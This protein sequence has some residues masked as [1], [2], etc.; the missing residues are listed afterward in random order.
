MK[1]LLLVFPLLL[2]AFIANAQNNTVQIIA[3]CLH[4]PSDGSIGDG[5]TDTSAS[6]KS[7]SAITEDTAGNLLIWDRGNA[8]IRKI[9]NSTHIVTTIAGTG[10][11]GFSGDGG[12]AVLAQLGAGPFLWN[13]GGICTDS[14]SNIYFADY[15][16]SRIR[17][18]NTVSGIINTIA[19]GG[20]SFNDSIDA[21]TA[22]VKPIKL[23]FHNNLLYFSDSSGK[24]K[25][26][27]LITN[28]LTTIYNNGAPAIIDFYFE[29]SGNLLILN[30]DSNTLKRMMPSGVIYNVAGNGTGYSG[31]GGPANNALLYDSWG[32]IE[33][34][35]GNIFI[36]QNEGVIRRINTSNGNI[37]AICGIPSITLVRQYGAIPNWG[38]YLIRS[39]RFLSCQHKMSADSLRTITRTN[40]FVRR[41]GSVIIA[42]DSQVLQYTPSTYSINTVSV[43]SSSTSPCAI[44]SLTK[45]TIYGTLNGTPPPGDTSINLKVRT[46]DVTTEINLPYSSYIDASGTHFFFGDS[47][48]AVDSTNY[49]WPQTKGFV[50]EIATKSRYPAAFY[51]VDTARA[52]C[53]SDTIIWGV[54]A[55]WDTVMSTYSCMDSSTL[56]KFKIDII[57]G[58]STPES[59]VIPAYPLYI[60]LIYGDG[61]TDTFI[62]NASPTGVFTMEV[63][64]IYNSTWLTSV[65]PIS[66]VTDRTGSITNNWDAEPIIFNE[67]SGSV[68]VGTSISIT[69]GSFVSCSAPFNQQ[70]FLHSYLE[71]SASVFDS[72]VYNLNFGD[73]TDTLVTLHRKADGWGRYYMSD[74]LY[75]NYTIAGVYNTLS[76]T[77]LTG[78]VDTTNA[79]TI[80]NTCSP[81]SGNFY[82]D[83]NMNCVLDSGEVRLGYW[84]FAVRN[85]VSG[86][87]TFWWCDS[88]GHYA[89]TL[90]DGVSYTIIPN[91]LFDTSSSGL[92]VT[93]PATGS[94]TLTTSASTPVTQDFGF[95]C[96]GAPTAVDMHISGWS[97]G[98]IPGDTGVLGIWASNDW[99]YM[100]DSLNSTVTLTLDTN[101]TYAGMWNGPAP[102]T[103]SGSTLT[104]NFHTTANL[105]DFTANV[106]IECATTA[107]MGDYVHNTIHVGQALPLADPDTA[108]N[109]YTWGVPVTTSWDPNEK[110]V[111]PQ[112]YG[113]LGYVPNGTP[114]T[115]TVHF[116][117]TGTARARNI[118]VNDTISEYLDISTLQVVSST[119]PVLVYQD[120]GTRIIRFRF[121]D[122]FLPDSTTN[123]DGSNGYFSFNIYPYPNLP[124]N[125][126][127]HN[128]VG[129]YFDY[130][131][132]VVTNTTTSTIEDTLH[133]IT[134]GAAS[135]CEGSS[136]TFSNALT[137]GVWITSNDHATVTEGIVTGVSAGVDTIYYSM[138]GGD[139][140]VQTI[141]TVNA[142]PHAGI[143]SGPSEVCVGSTIT[144]SGALSGGSWSSS[145]SAVATI[146]DGTVS[147]IAA[148]TAAISYAV[149]NSCGTD[150]ATAPVTVN[151]LPDAGVLSAAPWV[152]VED[153]TTLSSTV[154]GGVWTTADTTI[155]LT[156]TTINGISAGAATLYYAYTNVCGTDVDTLNITVNP[157]PV[158]GTLTGTTVLCMGG[159]ITLTATVPGG[160]WT[161]SSAV[162]TV[163]GGVV[164]GI[165]AGAL[166]I[167]YT[168]SNVCGIAFATR[169]VSVEAPMTPSVSGPTAV[170]TGTTITLTGSGTG[171]TWASSDAAATVV[172]GHVT[173]ISAG[174]AII[175]Y[176]QTNSCG[177]VTD[178][179]LVTV[180][181][182]P[183]AST[184]TGST[185]TCVGGVTTL[186]SAVSG[187]T[188]SSSTAAA[189]VTGG[190]VTGIAAG[191]TIITYT[192]SNMCGSASD[193]MML[194][195]IAPPDAGTISG[196]GVACVG[197]T[198]SLTA[199]VSS[200]TWSSS[201]AT[202][203][204]SPGGIANGVSLGSAIISYSVTNSCGTDVDTMLFSVISLPDAGTI[205][206]TPSVCVGGVST[207]TNTATG[208]EWLSS[209]SDADMVGGVVTGINA[210]TVTIFYSVTNMC[211]NASDTMMMTILPVPSLSAITGTTTLCAGRATTLS[212]STLGGT[213]S[214]SA[215]AI[216]T[217][218]ATGVVSGN[219]TGTTTISYIYSNSCGADTATASITVTTLP[220]AGSL[221]GSASVCPGAV[222]NLTPSIAGGSWVSGN[223]ALATVSSSGSVGG[224]TPGSVTI[225]YIIAN[226]CGADS[227]AMNITV[228][229]IIDCPDNVVAV[230]QPIG[231][232][233]YPN[234]NNGT[235]TISGY[236]AGV[237]GNVNAEI[238]N[239]LGQVI[240]TE[241]LTATNGSIQTLLQPRNLAAGSYTVRLN[242]D[243]GRIVLK[244]TVRD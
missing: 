178:T 125:T 131:P 230:T 133:A 169:S 194:S 86:D 81:L 145:S 91:H 175:S 172:A 6:F 114:F 237:N 121:N 123:P 101:L 241:Q 138:Y 137:G 244:F 127:I 148:G 70:F 7:I 46:G 33:D 212:N 189:T 129:I 80:T 96:A 164:T 155:S 88:M 150:I 188:W 206:G 219:T 67:C 240:Y 141:V 15:G 40:L 149:T 136:I 43:K 203:S 74:T 59:S 47:T 139:Q 134:G 227:A 2:F 120:P 170:C 213:W 92:G 195:V 162:A 28:L 225:Y 204:V 156:G 53:L 165:S 231:L 232:T 109:T 48:S 29:H 11:Y 93:C 83:A 208:G 157:L 113:P 4:C 190:S 85:N 78:E 221:T 224:V 144:L 210:G 58:V 154:A 107:T 60:K 160:T 163:S 37:N 79:V 104:W 12:P 49:D 142:L 202:V 71:G 199:T 41:N 215:T 239:V 185:F 201:S 68:I 122:I 30:H 10:T 126:Q 44:P 135:V 45:H 61:T 222:I 220:D 72:L 5:L 84:P 151:P 236:W 16:N 9:N 158:A 216:A 132:A 191:S 183:T 186:S 31:D 34:T 217:V 94:L 99:G 152:C 106:K 36:G 8:R 243:A 226:T 19:G 223:T 242:S 100:C 161:T 200:G 192:V 69:G 42:A 130:N 182:T 128:T 14:Q 176:A 26:L 193:T 63:D 180:N 110:Q 112:G 198:T 87:T 146:A 118:T 17:K 103:V 159:T 13:I 56:V 229:P 62:R 57:A 177:T 187:G 105:L 98:V 89:L 95:S 21:L 64:H 234:P 1:K 32:L 140:V 179:M 18:I 22:R 38:Y 238:V 51:I 90:G 116:Q 20:I 197:G 124:A 214:S 52:T 23:L 166:D 196:Y 171:G 65:T 73:G 76:T 39:S 207:L 143:L 55:L 173:G 153:A 102:T 108:N 54:G 168:V 117:N 209:T 184:I 77:L 218:D 119:A 115:Y 97:W 181:T 75:H 50:F 24:I 82:K 27:D 235:F 66:I 174:A 211:G 147:G 233:L 35:T 205:T 25:S 111:S 167:T 3:G 228:L